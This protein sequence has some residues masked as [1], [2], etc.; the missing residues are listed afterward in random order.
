MYLLY[1][2]ARVAGHYNMV[3]TECNESRGCTGHRLTPCQTPTTQ[4]SVFNVLL[5]LPAKSY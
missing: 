5:A 1:Y 2:I 3:D 4:G